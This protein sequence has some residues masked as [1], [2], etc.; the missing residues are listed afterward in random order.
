MSPAPTPLPLRR[1][2][3]RPVDAGLPARQSCALLPD[4]RSKLL[5][6][7]IARLP[8]DLIRMFGRLE[9]ALPMLSPVIRR[10]VRSVQTEDG[11]ISHGPGAGLRFNPAGANPGYALGTTEPVMQG[12]V[13]ELLAPGSVFYDIGANV[14]FFSVIAGRRVGKDGMVYAFEPVPANADALAHNIAINGFS[15][16]ELIRAAVSSTTGQAEFAEIGRASCRER[17]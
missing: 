5:R 14:G 6:K 1:A 13:A 16:I 10:V 3:A 8:P 2:A 4:R 12:K 15:N 7:L 17:V 11:V 9:K